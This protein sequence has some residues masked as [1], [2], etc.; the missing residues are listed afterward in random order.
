MFPFVM[1]RDGPPQLVV[2]RKHPAV[3]MPVLPRRWAEIGEQVEELTR[4]Q[5]DETA[6]AGPRELSRA[7]RADPVGGFVSGHHVADL[8]DEAGLA[9]DHGESL[10]RLVDGPVMG[11]FKSRTKALGAERGWLLPN[12]PATH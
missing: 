1:R 9:A 11:P 3:A 7:V 5:L 10:E 12:W 4:R 6:R 8:C 2:R